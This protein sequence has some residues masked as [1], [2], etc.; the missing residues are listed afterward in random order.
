MHLNFINGSIFSLRSLPGHFEGA[1]RFIKFSLVTTSNGFSQELWLKVD[2]SGPWTPG[3][4][5]SVTSG[6]AYGFWQQFATNIG[7]RAFV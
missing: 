2:A 5:L 6:Q 4:Y 1:G 3:A 7:T